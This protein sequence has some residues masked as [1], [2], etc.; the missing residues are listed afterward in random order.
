MGRI[1]DVLGMVDEWGARGLRTLPQDGVRFIG[2]RAGLR[3][4]RPL[5]LSDDVT[6]LKHSL[7][8][9]HDLLE[10]QLTPAWLAT[11][12]ACAANRKASCCWPMS[13]APAL[14]AYRLSAVHWSIRCDERRRQNAAEGLLARRGGEC[15]TSL[16][17]LERVGLKPL[18]LGCGVHT[19]TL[20][21]VVLT[22]VKT[23]D[24]VV[25][26]YGGDEVSVSHQR[27]ASPRRRGRSWPPPGRRP[28]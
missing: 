3:H 11:V 13:K 4:Q 6:C 16:L 10:G 23:Q 27:Q 21:D 25:G 26:C 20:N 18:S 19:G 22:F 9:R 12:A 1:D 28:R 7:Q 17:I 8:A 5:C 14:R 2:C 15:R 24:D